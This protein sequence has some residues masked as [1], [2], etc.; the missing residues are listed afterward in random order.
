[1]L[2]RAVAIGLGCMMAV[3]LF[4]AEPVNEIEHAFTRLYNFDFPGAHAALDR[5]IAS[6]PD[7]PM[8]YAMRASANLFYELDRLSIL[9]SEFFS[10]DRRIADKKRPK[11]DPVI[12][13]SLLRSIE[14]PLPGAGYAG[15][16][17]QR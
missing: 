6:H 1:M 13:A 9:E 11:P 7:D 17:S 10:D 2:Q 3:P 8:G 14:A 15:E 4:C 5:H 12:R 16:E